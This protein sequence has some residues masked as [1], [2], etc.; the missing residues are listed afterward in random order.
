MKIL[1][2]KELDNKINSF[3]ERKMTE[4]PE[5]RHEPEVHITEPTEHASAFQWVRDMVTA[6]Q[7][8]RL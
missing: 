1:N 4:Y 5:L 8:V 3:M 2:D 7:S 6:I